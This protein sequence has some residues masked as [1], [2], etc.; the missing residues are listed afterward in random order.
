MLVKKQFSLKESDFDV[1]VFQSPRYGVRSDY[2][3]VYR[4]VMTSSSSE[5][6]LET[7]YRR[8]NVKDTLPSKYN[9]RYINL[10]DIVFIDKGL[11]GHEYYQ[12]QHEGWEKIPRLRLLRISR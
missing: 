5:D 4:G 7:I 9:G 11:E 12:L 6:V 8:L 3:Q 2:R 10:G 1:T